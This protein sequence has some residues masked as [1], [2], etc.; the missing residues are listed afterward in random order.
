MF[1][2]VYIVSYEIHKINANL[3]TYFIDFF[4]IFVNF[5]LSIHLLF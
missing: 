5:I 3:V 2:T 4:P 1:A